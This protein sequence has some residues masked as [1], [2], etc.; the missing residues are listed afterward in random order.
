MPIIGDGRS[1]TLA[2]KKYFDETY[3]PWGSIGFEIDDVGYSEQAKA[4]IVKCRFFQ[5][6]VATQKTPYEITI[7]DD[8]RILKAKKL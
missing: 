2:A 7:A 6:L 5:S 8:G 4:W 3:G 1:A